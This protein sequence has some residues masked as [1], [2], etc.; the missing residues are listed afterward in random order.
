MQSQYASLSIQHFLYFLP[1][2]QGHLSL[3]PIFPMLNCVLTGNDE[4]CVID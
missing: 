2:P 3:R 4:K 1:E